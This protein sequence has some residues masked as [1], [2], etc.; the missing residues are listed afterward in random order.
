MI[1]V[2]SVI[3][4]FDGIGENNKFIRV[5]WISPNAEDL[6]VINI[7]NSKKM[8]FPHFIK[9]EDLLNDLEESRAVRIDYEQDLHII[10]PSDE[11]LEKYAMK[12]KRKWD[13]I[14]EIVTIEPDIYIPTER[15]KLLRS[16]NDKTGI[17]YN[18][19]Y[20]LL[21]R[22]CFYGKCIN[23]LLPNYFDSG[24]EG[25]GRKYTK[26]P[27]RKGENI[28][29]LDESDFENF[30]SAVEKFRVIEKKSILE[31][32]Q[33]MCEEYYPSSYYRDRGVLVPLVDESKAP[34]A[35]QFRYW[36]NKN[37]SVRERKGHSLGQRRTKKEFRAL[38]GSNSMY[39][40]G[41][42][43]LYQ[44]DST[45]ADVTLLALD[46]KTEIKRP[47]LF[48]VQDVFSRKIVGYHVSVH[49]AN[50]I[51]GAMMA[52]ENAA[53]NKVEFCEKYGVPIKPEEWDCHHLPRHIVA[54]RGEMKSKYPNGL[55]GIG[56][57]IANTPSY[58]PDLKAVI[59]Q[60]FHI[61]NKTIKDFFRNHGAILKDN[62][63]RGES[64]PAPTITLDT[65]NIFMIEH[66]IAFN[67]M[68]LPREFIVTP[69]M[70]ND[71]VE[72][73]PNGLWE[74]GANKNLLHERPKNLIHYTL[75]PKLTAKVTR[76]GL[77]L[78]ANTKLCYA[79]R[80]GEEAEWFVSG[81]IEGMKEIEVS[82]DPRDCSAILIRLK[83]GKLLHCFLTEKFNEYRGLNFEDAKAI[84]EFK[85]QQYAKQSNSDKNAK[86]KRRAL[87]EKHLRADVE[88]KKA[89]KSSKED[90]PLGKREAT[91]KEAEFRDSV[92]AFTKHWQEQPHEF[93]QEEIEIAEDAGSFQLP[94]A[95]KLSDFL[96]SKHKEMK[97]GLHA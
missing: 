11:Y 44:I 86:S 84:F 93:I 23:G 35:K 96:R 50:W 88:A 27:G 24:A 25:K 54:D 73:T 31:T 66:I 9:M 59:E 97:G 48:M 52:L 19:L 17:G 49:H 62:R 71:H 53:S 7:T 26:K 55:V 83:S 89:A 65:F 16:V 87:V 75:L 15:M 20:D 79:C 22:Y 64:A 33:R 36:Y 41:P 76:F 28:K 68:T 85:K 56:V 37:Y 12:L 18:V 38:L 67:N 29:V 8:P 3:Q 40:E 6:A 74:W 60:H 13:L 1:F 92:D 51:D 94:T 14:K 80:E 72:L 42:G 34:S 43:Y 5:C 63:E 58:R 91:A 95:N 69:E 21:K 77:E 10:N 39:I 90:K 70:F 2:N 82:Y 45:P 78:K 61:T 46:H 32:H 57:D 30:K 47:T 81:S 4:L